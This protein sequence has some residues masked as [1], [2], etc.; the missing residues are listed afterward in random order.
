MLLLVV[1]VGDGVCV[2]ERVVVGELGDQE[3]KSHKS[4]FSENIQDLGMIG[5]EENQQTTQAGDP[6]C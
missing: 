1:V 6:Y 5:T 3:G 2:R 4:I